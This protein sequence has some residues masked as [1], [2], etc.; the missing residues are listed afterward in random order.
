MPG[1]RRPPRGG[2]RSA[3]Q[4][5]LHIGIQGGLLDLED[6]VERDQR[7]DLAVS[8][9]LLAEKLAQELQEAADSV[10]VALRAGRARAQVR[11]DLHEQA[12]LSREHR[13]DLD[14]VLFGD[15]V[16][17]VA[18]EFQIAAVLA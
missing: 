1:D 6:G 3:G 12:H 13:V 9:L 14:E 16:A 18:V 15:L 8:K 2:R 17:A 4:R 11:G 5:G 7:A 10:V